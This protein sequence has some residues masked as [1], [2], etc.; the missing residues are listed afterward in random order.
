MKKRKITNLKK[1]KFKPFNNYG[2]NIPGMNWCKIT[3]NEE[4]GQ[5]TYVL[6]VEPGAKS[7]HHRHINFEEFLM[8][9]GE[10]TDSDK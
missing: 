1:L 3:Y 8:L 6:K 9:N 4:T 7:P 10:L 5:G 2:S